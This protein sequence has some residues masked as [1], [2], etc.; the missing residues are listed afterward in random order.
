MNPS[1]L[2]ILVTL[3]ISTVLVG[4]TKGST[5]TPPQDK[6]IDLNVK[7]RTPMPYENPIDLKQYEAKSTRVVMYSSDHASAERLR[8]TEADNWD[9]LNSEMT[10]LREETLNL[11]RHIEEM[12]HGN[13]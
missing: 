3:V 2:I 11:K 8:V 7:Q 13:K 5:S 4:L 9:R 6:S 1:D 12:N 10:Q